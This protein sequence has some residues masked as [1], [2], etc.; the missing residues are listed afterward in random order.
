MKKL[1]YIL[2]PVFLLVAFLPACKPF[3][4][5][6]DDLDISININI[7]KTK[8]AVSFVDAASGNLVGDGADI[9]IHS[10]VLGS[11]VD[12]VIDNDAYFK[13]EYDVQDGYFEFGLNPYGKIPSQDN[14]V[15]IIV[16]AEAPGYL[17]TSM[18]VTII[19]EG[20]TEV[21]I[22]MVNINDPCDGVA[23]KKVWRGGTAVNGILQEDLTAE[24]DNRDL[25]IMVKK[26]TELT[27]RDGS[28]LEGELSVVLAYFSPIEEEALNAFPG[29]FTV[30]V[31][32]ENNQVQ[33][34]NFVTA[35]FVAI[36][37]TDPNGNLAAQFENGNLEL[38]ILINPAVINYE[39]D[40]PIQE[41]DV[42]PVWS[43]QVETGAWT[44]EKQI[45]VGSNQEGLGIHMDLHHL[46]WYNLDWFV[47]G[48][49]TR[50]K[51]FIFASDQE[52]G[53]DQL[54]CFNFK[55]Y[56]R[57]G[58]GWIYWKK[59][60][61]RGYTSD[62]TSRTYY[63]YLGWQNAPPWEMKIVF[64]P[65]PTCDDPLFSTPPEQI[66]EFC[67]NTNEVIYITPGDYHQ[68]LVEAFINCTN[69]G[70]RFKV[71]DNYRVR[72]RVLGNTCWTY[73]WVYK[74]TININPVWQNT[75]YEVQVFDDGWEPG[76]PYQKHIGTEDHLIVNIDKECG[77]D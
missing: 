18:P 27:D 68:V 10:S 38:D 43:H 49:C 34:G 46:S 69:T 55:L 36:E 50:S 58:S 32:D 11:D 21:E 9:F 47:T 4:F 26:G 25:R 63:N 8:V 62:G 67:D 60:Q 66:F 77:G 54:F 65:C 29:G 7:I 42:I 48:Y 76:T 19:H 52:R 30:T 17:Q 72:Y 28:P 75:T 3:E 64:E 73:Q 14:P 57:S 13:T 70:T 35:G 53:Y 39:T 61:V 45:T 23:I 1:V 22:P 33:D 71:D 59:H 12:Q 16:V 40:Q 74:G 6:E 41:N 51:L 56:R 24:T 37:I 2:L 15:K 5:S 44:F 20:F 31:N